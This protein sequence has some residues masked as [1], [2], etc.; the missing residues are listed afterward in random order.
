M[1]KTPHKTMIDSR[2]SGA[3]RSRAGSEIWRHSTCHLDRPAQSFQ[4]PVFGSDTCV[5]SEQPSNTARGAQRNTHTHTQA[6]THTKQKWGHIFQHQCPTVYR[7]ACT[8]TQP[9]QRHTDRKRH[10]LS[11]VHNFLLL[12]RAERTLRSGEV[13][14]RSPSWSGGQTRRLTMCG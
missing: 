7:Q 1:H 3:E 14:W 4:S 11:T 9:T 13:K 10:P 8:N 5:T 6:G 2:T 12:L